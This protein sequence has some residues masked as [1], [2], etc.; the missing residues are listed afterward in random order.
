M[1]LVVTPSHPSIDTQLV[2]YDNLD[3]LDTSPG[4]ISTA[5]F[6]RG[7]IQALG[8]FGSGTVAL[9][10]SNNGTT[11]VNL[12]N[13]AGS[14]IGLTAAGMSL[15]LV[16]TRYIRPLITGGTGDDVDIFIFLV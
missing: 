7:S 12:S 8:T 13:T 5:G 10:G 3:T 4:A 1:A 11:W 14:A 9:Q 15:F 6:E 16:H 2:N